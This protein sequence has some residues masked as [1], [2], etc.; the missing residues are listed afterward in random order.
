MTYKALTSPIA[1][2]AAAVLSLSSAAFGQ[3][4]VGGQE[5]NQGSLPSVTEHCAM[6]AGQAPT[7]ATETHANSGNVDAEDNVPEEQAMDMSATE[8]VDGNS[9]NIEAE[10]N[11]PEGELADV[12]ATPAPTDPQ[13][14]TGN[15]DADDNV[16][17]VNLQAITLADCQEAGLAS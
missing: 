14:Q 15:A 3:T 4:M 5:V 16:G 9:G 7:S 8:E 17:L 12:A 1:L 13:P 2:T 11:L 10:D 6:L